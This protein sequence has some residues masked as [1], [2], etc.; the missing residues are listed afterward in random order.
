[1]EPSY[2][3]FESEGSLLLNPSGCRRLI[4]HLL[5]L[6]HT[7][8]NISF[9]VHK[10]SKFVSNP[11]ESHIIVALRVLRYLKGCPSVG[12][13]FPRNNQLVCE[14]RWLQYIF[15]SFVAYCDNKIAICIA[16]NPHFLSARSTLKLIVI[17]FGL[18]FKKTSFI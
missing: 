9:A 5:Y 17:S 16:N 14:P 4:G 11:Q 3:L 15:E 8:P 10:L 1:M 7:R 2:P 6:T 12:L 13:F 18:N